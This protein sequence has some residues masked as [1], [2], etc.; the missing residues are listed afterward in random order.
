LQ[1]FSVVTVNRI[2]T[3]PLLYKQTQFFK[4]CWGRQRHL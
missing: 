2:C 4:F 1:G 3:L